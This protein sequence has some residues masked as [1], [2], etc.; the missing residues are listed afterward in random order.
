MACM[1][2]VRRVGGE[3][4]VAGGGSEWVALVEGALVEGALEGEALVMVAWGREKAEKKKQ[5]RKE[6]AETR[7]QW[8]L[9]VLRM[10]LAGPMVEWGVAVLLLTF[11]MRAGSVEKDTRM[12][13]R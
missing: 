13:Q 10:P 8:E 1:L 3:L 9:V 6:K 2:F 5:K 12:H 7:L 11:E 4:G